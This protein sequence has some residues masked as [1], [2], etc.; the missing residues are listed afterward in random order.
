MYIVRLCPSFNDDNLFNV[1]TT[2]Y[3]HL[4]KVTCQNV[5]HVNFRDVSMCFTQKYSKTNEKT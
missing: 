2:T 3:A 1:Y 5:D 4:P